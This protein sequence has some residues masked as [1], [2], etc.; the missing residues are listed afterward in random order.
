MYF[1]QICNKN[2]KSILA[3]NGHKR[4]HIDEGKLHNPMCCCLIT[5]RNIVAHKLEK[6][7]SNLKNCLFC[8]AT[9]S[10]NRKFCDTSCG[11]KFNNDQRN[12]SNWTPSTE[13][14]SKTSETLKINTVLSDQLIVG[15][16]SK[17]SFISC[18]H[19]GDIFTSKHRITKCDNCKNIKP[20]YRKVYAFKFD[21]QQYPDLFDLEEI[22]TV[23]WYSPT[24][25]AN[26]NLNGLTKDH[27]ISAKEADNNNYDPFYITHPLNCKIITQSENSSKNTKS[28]MSYEELTQLV[29]SY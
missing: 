27:I 11:A 21:V 16:F 9:L 10:T 20:N 29:D 3:L 25:K 26:R 22:K 7:Q 17:I 23:G 13:H 4:I 15:K 24:K 1:C 19:C 28:Y 12:I 2:F 6:F 8:H 5:K 18:A 14:R